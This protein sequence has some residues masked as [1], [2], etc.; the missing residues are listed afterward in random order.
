MTMNKTVQIEIS[1]DFIKLEQFLKLADIV[2]TGGEAKIFIKEN[3]IFVNG[4]KEDRRGRKLY[5]EDKIEIEGRVFE[6]CG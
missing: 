3:D 5:P 2:S 4:E 1:T 6:I